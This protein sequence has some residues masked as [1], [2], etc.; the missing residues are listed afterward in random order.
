MHTQ[1]A[2]LATLAGEPEDLGA[3]SRDGLEIQPPPAAVP[4]IL[5][6]TG[7]PRSRLVEQDR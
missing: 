2:T 7:T 4:A 5:K 3:W 6:F 1:T